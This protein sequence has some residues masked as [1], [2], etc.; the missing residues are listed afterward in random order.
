MT[1]DDMRDLVNIK[2]M[3][4]LAECHDAF[5]DQFDKESRELN[6]PC[7]FIFNGDDI[8]IDED[9]NF[10]LLELNRCPSIS[11]IGH[12][13]IKDMT[14]AMLKEMID[15]VLEIREL[16][17][18]GHVVDQDTTLSSQSKWLRCRLDYKLPIIDRVDGLINDLDALLK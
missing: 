8:M 11:L 2:C 18:N 15:I 12:Q 10:L 16:K 17:I 5:K 14:K 3:R 9:G 6:R 1:I 7:Q 13:S 4:L